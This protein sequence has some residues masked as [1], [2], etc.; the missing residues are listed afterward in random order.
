MAVIPTLDTP[1]VAPSVTPSASFDVQTPADA[2]GVGEAQAKANQAVEGAAKTAEEVL[3]YHQKQAAR[4][5]FDRNVTMPLLQKRIELQEKAKNT[6]GEAALNMQGPMEAEFEKSAKDFEVKA[7]GDPEAIAWYN[8]ELE[9]NRHQLRDTLI[10][11]KTSEEKKLDERTYQ[12]L[13]NQAINDAISHRADPQMSAGYKAVA[14]GRM[15]DYR[16]LQ[17]YGDNDPIHLSDRLTINT[18]FA[19]GIVIQS[20]QDGN[21]P[22]A[23]AYYKTVEGGMDRDKANELNQ[24]I[25]YAQGYQVSDDIWKAT[26]RGANGEKL[27]GWALG[28][29]EKNK[30][31]TPQQ[32]TE[33]ANHIYDF[34]RLDTRTVNGQKADKFRAFEDQ[35]YQLRKQN[36]PMD[37]AK[38]LILGRGWDN[39]DMAKANKIV[40][41]IYSP[42]S[43]K[44]DPQVLMEFTQGIHLGH[45]TDPA[46]I[47]QAVH[48]GVLTPTDGNKMN[49]LLN[50]VNKNG[51]DPT[52]EFL[53]DSLNKKMN[54]AFGNDPQRKSV[55]FNQFWSKSEKAKDA[56]TVLADADKELTPE[57]KGA[58]WF[59]RETPQESGQRILENQSN[60]IKAYQIQLGQDET[61]AI[62][63][64]LPSWK[65]ADG[66]PM[67]TG[68]AGLSAFINAVPGGLE[69]LKPG[70]PA[71]E[72]IRTLERY[73]SGH[74]QKPIPVTPLSIQRVLGTFPTGIG[75]IQ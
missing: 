19:D 43:F 8:Q 73:N 36:A 37:D 51:K 75:T 5:D 3:A 41:Q 48:Q 10:T 70:N 30:D 60:S 44:T 12:G 23:Q 27:L 29:I 13:T 67:P 64:G 69:A 38:K 55:W 66:R 24:K 31:L 6:F 2:F 26:P 72:A 14:M 65:S 18:Q 68:V 35:V 71:N 59:H 42:S 57:Q 11:Q 32:K 17:G 52:R 7:V 33:V 15:A 58:P 9:N 74:P 62:L 53:I 1:Q 45:I 49:D 39:V 21:I 61:Q 34:S 4:A 20:L 22:A 28:Q 56:A 40:E 46:Q 50:K 54:S 25:L 16:R 47:D 63:R